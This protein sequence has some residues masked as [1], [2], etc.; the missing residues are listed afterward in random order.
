MY[1]KSDQKKHQKTPTYGAA[2]YLYISMLV[3]NLTGWLL[4]QSVLESGL[5]KA[6][7][8]DLFY[9]IGFLLMIIAA[10]IQ[11]LCG[12]KPFN[13]ISIQTMEFK[14]TGIY[15]RT[16][17][18]IYFSWWLCGIGITL[19]MHNMW[20]LLLIPIQWVILTVIIR[21]TEEKWLYE[22]HG[23]AYKDYCAKVNRWIPLK[24]IG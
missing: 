1:L 10:R 11:W 23:D 12:V 8:K 5:L 7:F 22:I 18:P 17:N 19:T 20:L 9:L 13:S 24:K 4:S 15:A 21:N 3:L 6:G 14:T 16:R 2:P